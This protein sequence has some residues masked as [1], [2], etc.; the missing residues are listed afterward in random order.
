MIHKNYIEDSIALSVLLKVLKLFKEF[1]Q[2]FV[3]LMLSEY[4][5]LPIVTYKSV[6][7]L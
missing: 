2:P 3:E 5:K 6:Y 4:Q 1:V 7:S